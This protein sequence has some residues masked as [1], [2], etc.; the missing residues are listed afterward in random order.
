M[1]W[2]GP[3]YSETEYKVL[4]EARDQNVILVASAGNNANAKP[5]YPAAFG[6][7]TTTQPWETNDSRLVV[8]VASIDAYNNRS[9][10]SS[11]AQWVDVSAYG[12]GILSTVANSSGGVHIT[13]EYGAESGTSLAAP[14]VAGLAGLMRSYQPSKS[15]EEIIDCL[16]NTANADIYNSISHPGNL[17]GTLGSGR[18]DAH[19]ALLCLGS[20]CADPLAVIFPSAITICSGGSVSLTANEGTTYQ[21]STSETTRTITVTSAGTYSVTVTFDGSCTASTS[22]EIVAAPTSIIIFPTET[23]GNSPNDGLL[24]SSGLSYF[25]PANEVLNLTA[26]WGL[27][28]EWSLPGETGQSVF[29]NPVDPP[30]AGTYTVTVTGVGGCTGVTSTASVVIRWFPY[31]N[32]SIQMEETSGIS[33]DGL[34]CLGESIILNGDGG[35]SY[36]W[37][38]TETTSSITVEPT[39][40]TT[41]TVTVTSADGC[42]A[43]TEQTISVSTCVPANDCA[44]CNVLAGG[45]NIVASDDGTLYSTLGLSSTLSAAPCLAISGKLIIDVDV[46]IEDIP[47]IRMGSGAEIVVGGDVALPLYPTLEIENCVIKACVQMW[48]GINVMPQA[49][50][51]FNSNDIQDAEYALTANAS[52]A[53]SLW[54]PTQIEI[55]NNLFRHNHVGFYAPVAAPWSNIWHYPFTGNTFITLLTGNLKPPS[56]ANVANYD[57]TSGYAGVV[58]L[59]GGAFTVGTPVTSGYAN[60]FY[61]LRNGII[62]GNLWLNVHRADFTYMLGYMGTT[63]TPSFNYSRGVGI[64]CS[65]IASITGSRFTACGHGIYS[66]GGYLTVWNNNLADVWTGVQ[67]NSNAGMSINSENYPQQTIRFRDYGILAKNLTKWLDYSSF[68]IENNAIIDLSNYENLDPDQLNAAILINNTNNPDMPDGT[69]VIDQNEIELTS[70]FDGISVFNTNNWD[71]YDNSVMIGIHASSQSRGINLTNANSAYLLSNVIEGLYDI[72]PTPGYTGA[73]GV[74][75]NSSYETEFCCNYI[76]GTSFGVDFFG[77]C[78]N[79]ILRTTDLYNHFW[80]IRCSES[81]MLGDQPNLITDPTGNYGNLFEYQSAIAEHDGSDAFISDSEFNVKDDN[82]P[83]HPGSFI[84]IYAQCNK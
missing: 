36:L 14:Q 50:L 84:Y 13:N 81:T 31:P 70:T 53:L 71:I 12:T 3:G 18:I 68:K 54:P 33:N 83:N 32:P 48:K 82:I 21:W 38:T 25:P 66:N 8:A 60:T 55:E 34:V 23:S 64:S 62:A 59:G 29:F 78:E 9:F 37:S 51:I 7:G 75:I 77:P 45:I 35:N 76:S 57:A 41:Y 17:A 10:F 65:G 56:D 58:L 80:S 11:F 63:T 72:L 15:D 73:K 4:K 61:N 43:T 79:T 42:S 39:L 46:T 26:T 1:S 44:P 6:E 47:D 28:Y 74:E 5:V 30:Y 20:D 16:L 22:I 69:A 27:S 40:L 24:C 67:L 49:H 19:Q 2:G 52:S